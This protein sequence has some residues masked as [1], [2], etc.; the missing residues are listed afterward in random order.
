MCHTSIR[1][2]AF[3]IGTVT[4]IGSSPRRLFNWAS[5]FFPKIHREIV[6]IVVASLFPPLAGVNDVGECSLERK[7]QRRYIVHTR[8][9]RLR[10]PPPMMTLKMLLLNI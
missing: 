3:I 1:H 4:G 10:R 9:S 5:K 6:K 8:K 2:P 7:Q